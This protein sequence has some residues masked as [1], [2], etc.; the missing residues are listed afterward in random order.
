MIIV[1]VVNLILF[2]KVKSYA[3]LLIKL[4]LLNFYNIPVP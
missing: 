1:N 3:G 2:Y 4:A